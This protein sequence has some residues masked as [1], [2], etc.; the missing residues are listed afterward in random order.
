MASGNPIIRYVTTICSDH[1]KVESTMKSKIRF[2]FACSN[3]V[4]C[5]NKLDLRV[6]A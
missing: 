4:Y 6:L 3:R 5:L 1:R 2:L